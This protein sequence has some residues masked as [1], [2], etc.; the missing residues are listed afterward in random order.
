[1]VLIVIEL[2]TIHMS[3]KQFFVGNNVHL[4]RA[5]SDSGIYI[6]MLKRSNEIWNG[7]HVSMQDF[8]SEEH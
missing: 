6:D 7:V 1:M 5:F 4:Y 3:Q 8:S 2:C